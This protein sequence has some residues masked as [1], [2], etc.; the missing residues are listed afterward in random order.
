M[1]LVLT[2]RAKTCRKCGFTIA[3]E[4]LCYSTKTHAGKRYLCKQCHGEL[5]TDSKD[6][7]MMEADLILADGRKITVMEFV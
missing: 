1:N 2:K 6:E 4:T 5:F 3:E 7:V